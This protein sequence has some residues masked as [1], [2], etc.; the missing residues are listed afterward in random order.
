METERQLGRSSM[1]TGSVEFQTP[2]DG[3][4]DLSPLQDR[5]NYHQTLVFL[6]KARRQFE[7]EDWKG[8]VET[9]N[10]RYTLD[11]VKNL[12][13]DIY[14]G[15]ISPQ[16]VSANQQLAIVEASQFAGAQIKDDL[17]TY[18]KRKAGQEETLLRASKVKPERK[19]K[20][21]RLFTPKLKHLG[22]LAVAGIAAGGY[23]SL[24]TS[25]KDIQSQDET[26]PKVAQIF[27]SPN[28]SPKEDIPEENAESSVLD[29]VESIFVKKIPKVE[30]LE[31]K[32]EGQFKFWGIDFSVQ[33]EIAGEIK[34]DEIIRLT[35]EGE[36]VTAKRGS[37]L[38][39]VSAPLAIE[40]GVSFPDYCLKRTELDCVLAFEKFAV[41]GGHSGVVEHVNKEGITE[42]I[43]L[44]SEAVRAFVEGHKFLKDGTYS[45]A[46]T[47]Q[48]REAIIALLEK[49]EER[50][51][52]SQ[53]EVQVKVAVAV[54]RI[55]EAYRDDVYKNWSKLDEVVRARDPDLGDKI[56]LDAPHFYWVI[57][58]RLLN[59]D[60]PS[61]E[62]HSAY[63]SS[64][65]VLALGEPVINSK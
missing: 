45:E 37:S 35:W 44:T 12:A 46:L 39:I 23:F 42:K 62:N 9:K 63:S 51:I 59:G 31:V 56:N 27:D 22:P 8:G 5:R 28:K 15:N 26:S 21:L 38:K 10:G 14:R 32:R 29:F 43:E 13:T 1:G 50:P 53:G 48:E 54:V 11:D 65:I 4:L 47:S 34:K 19:P 49:E 33:K 41:S 20:P 25:Q 36:G 58:G 61:A 3:L 16:L 64:I 2:S 6:N 60:K 30:E 52:L 55:E 57:S 40:S 18:L 24:N 17:I 7:E